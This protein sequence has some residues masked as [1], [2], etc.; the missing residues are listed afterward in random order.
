MR[1]FSGEG[2]AVVI[3]THQG[4][5]HQASAD[6]K[7]LRPKSSGD[8]KKNLAKP[9]A[10]LILF[11]VSWKWCLIYT[12]II[13]IYNFSVHDPWEFFEWPWEIREK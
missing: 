9:S 4:Q 12:I 2:E 3:E 6:P 8:F 11:I 10:F 13:Q 7:N 1:K 5:S